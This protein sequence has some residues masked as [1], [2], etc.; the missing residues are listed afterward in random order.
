[1]IQINAISSLFKVTLDITDQNET[2]IETNPT[3][4]IIAIMEKCLQIYSIT[5]STSNTIIKS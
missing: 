4:E 1:M 2:Y 3:Q 5:T